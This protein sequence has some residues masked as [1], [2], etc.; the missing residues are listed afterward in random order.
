[1]LWQILFYKI[2]IEE[3]RFMFKTADTIIEEEMIQMTLEIWKQS[4]KTI[5]PYLCA[6]LLIL[7]TLI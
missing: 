4:S 6:I 7:N 5:S 3:S 1:M 2:E